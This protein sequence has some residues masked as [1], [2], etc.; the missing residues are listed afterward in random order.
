MWNEG[1]GVD[2]GDDEQE[3]ERMYEMI[4]SYHQK[5]SAAAAAQRRDTRAGSTDTGQTIGSPR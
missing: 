1:A 4:D 5:R 3:I 2:V